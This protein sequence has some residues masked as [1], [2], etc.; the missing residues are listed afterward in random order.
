MSE[1]SDP[2]ELTGATTAEWVTWVNA[3]V[4]YVRSIMGDNEA[5]HVR[6]DWVRGQVLLRIA[7]NPGEPA[8]ELARAVLHLSALDYSRWYS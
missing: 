7:V 8:D 3:E 6:E 5:A 2:P 4:E 1:R